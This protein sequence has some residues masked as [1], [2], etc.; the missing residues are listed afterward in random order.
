MTFES[1]DAIAEALIF[2]R[3]A[4]DRLKAA[5]AK[6]ALAKIRAAITASQ[7]ALQQQQGR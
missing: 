3:A 4:R 6:G 2:L 5:K 1:Q 7:N